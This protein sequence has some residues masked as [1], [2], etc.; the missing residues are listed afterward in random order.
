MI[1]IKKTLAI[2]LAAL[3]VGFVS[4]AIVKTYVFPQVATL[5]S[6]PTV[7]IFVNGTEYTDGEIMNF[8]NFTETGTTYT[9]NLT[10]SN[11]GLVVCN[12]TFLT[13]G[14]P[15]GWSQTWA[16]N[17]TVLQVGEREVADLCITTGTV[18][19]DYGWTSTIHL[20]KA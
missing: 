10:V 16:G 3:L 19:G 17:H 6:T 14:L 20:E 18:D 5:A 2:I 4:G 12:V 15:E 7:A 1:T 8:G 13:S 11:T 9:Y